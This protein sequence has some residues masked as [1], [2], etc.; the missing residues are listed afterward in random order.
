MVKQWTLCIKFLLPFLHTFSYLKWSN[1]S[2]VKLLKLNKIKSILSVFWHLVCLCLSHSKYVN[3]ICQVLDEGSGM[4]CG[5]N[6]EGQL[7]V[8][9]PTMMLEY[10]NNHTANMETI[11][12]EGFIHTGDLGFYDEQGFVHVTDHVRETIK[13]RTYLVMFCFLVDGCSWA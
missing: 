13:W 1:V 10:Y 11:D 6:Q 12:S 2:S 5:I 8:R 3:K 7:C 4:P 9:S